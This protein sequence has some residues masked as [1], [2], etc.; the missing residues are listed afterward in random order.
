MA[1]PLFQFNSQIASQFR[2]LAQSRL[3]RAVDR[4][5]I[6]IQ[7][8]SQEWLRRA[9]RVTP[10]EDGTLAGQWFV[11][12]IRNGNILTIVL[13]N[14]MAYGR[15]LEFGTRHIA[16]GHVL[17]WKYGDPPVMN[18]P[19][20][21]GTLQKPSSRASSATH[22]KWS[23]RMAGAMTPGQGEQMPMARA[24]GYGLLSQIIADVQKIIA[25]ELGRQ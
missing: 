18:W 7:R 23:K 16:S 22:E 12:P 1:E 10:R 13:A 25:D 15:W 11:V 17:A 9:A 19:A 6:A 4:A 8:W 24:T 2:R 14:H 21:A 3:D 5:W 20:K